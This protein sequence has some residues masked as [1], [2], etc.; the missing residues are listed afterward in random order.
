MGDL[1]RPP[2][3]RGIGQGKQGNDGRFN[4]RRDMHRPGIVCHR[5]IQLFP[6]GCSMTSEVCSKRGVSLA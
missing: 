2:L 6:S 4:R 5:Q 1:P 3:C